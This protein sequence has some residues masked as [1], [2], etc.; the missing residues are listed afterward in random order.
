MASAQSIILHHY[1]TSPFSEKVR[2][3]LRM[4]NLAWASVEIPNM[5]PKPLLM[6]LTGGY[7]KTP[8]MQIGAD[9]FLDSAMIIRAL[10]ERFEIPQLDLPGHEGLSNV[11]GY[12]LTENGSRPASPSFSARSAIRC[13]KPS[14]KTANS[15]QAAHSIPMP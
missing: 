6:P 1:Q 11:V 15:F 13:R 7:R 8:V 5:M 3:A 14:R 10:E 12:G 4:K 2:L 9:I